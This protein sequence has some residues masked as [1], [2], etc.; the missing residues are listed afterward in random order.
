MCSRHEVGAYLKK[1]EYDADE[2]V[3]TLERLNEY[4]YLDDLEVGRQVVRKYAGRY[5]WQYIALKLRQKGLV[6]PELLQELRSLSD[7]AAEAL[8]AKILLEK[9]RK[10]FLVDGVFDRRKAARFLQNRGYAS[11][12]IGNT[13]HIMSETDLD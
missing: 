4:G 12:V 1:R 2:I 5:G 3:A 7:N 9:N 13:L 11:A 6:S 8:N 10:R